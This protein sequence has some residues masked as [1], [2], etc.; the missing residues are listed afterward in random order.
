MK[1]LLV[2]TL[3]ILLCRVR[4]L[5]AQAKDPEMPLIPGVVDETDSSFYKKAVK[6]TIDGK[7]AL[8]ADLY[9]NSDTLATGD[10]L[11]PSIKMNELRRITVL[12]W[13]KYKRGGSY[14]FYP[15]KYEVTFSDSH[16]VVI[17]GNIK[18]LNR[19]RLKINS[20]TGYFYMFYYDY[21]KKN[22]WQNSGLA[23]FNTSYTRPADGCITSI[24]VIR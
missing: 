14:V 8:D 4:P 15:S 1:R 5:D 9:F 22:R 21:Y 23:D 20:K 18:A 2:F 19:L 13:V 24:E 17:D 10:S 11:V 6:V 7:G 16:K 12:L 3:I